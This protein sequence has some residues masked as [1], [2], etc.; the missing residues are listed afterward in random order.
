MN[1]RRLIVLVAAI[2]AAHVE[3]QV[4][5]QVQVQAF[6]T[7]PIKLVVPFP[8]GGATDTTAR[9]ISQQLQTRL[10]QSVIIENQGGAGGSIGAKQVANATPDG[11]TLLMSSASTFGTHPVLYR[12]DYDP[13]KAFAPVA[14]AVV[15]KL[16]LVAGPAL[17]VNNVQELVAYAKAHPGELNYGN[18]IGIGPHFTAEMFKIKSGANIQHIPYRGGAPMIADL[19]AGQIHMTINGKSVLLPHIQGGKVRA[20]GVT[21]AERWADMPDVPTLL[22][23]GYLDDPYD[24]S[25]GI[26]A[27]AGTPVAAIARLNGV[28]NEALR[29]PETRAA[30][31]RLGIEP[32]ITTPQEFAALIAV[33][34]PRWAKAVRQTGI[35]VD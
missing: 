13:L 1:E 34:A 22:E 3:V 25:F 16:V 17:A 23:L 5:A 15:D 30:L 9:L 28:I 32:K 2:L 24:V 31:E 33:E 35:K 27:P 12:L 14:T 10:G 11:H 4:Q 8:P 26:V 19:V 6:P 7:K 18:A 20:L 29:S 21:A